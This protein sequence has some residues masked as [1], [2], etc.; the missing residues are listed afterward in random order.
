MI[1]RVLALV[2]LS[3]LRLSAATYYVRTNGNDSADGSSGTPW[4]TVAKAATTAS[5][6]DTVLIGPGRFEEYV[7]LTRSNVVFRGVGDASLEGFRVNDAPGITLEALTFRGA[8]NSLG[9]HVRV[10]NDS[11]NLTITN[12]VIGPGLFAFEFPM[13][14]NPTNS[15]VSNTNVDWAA[16]GFKVGGVIWMGSSGLTNY[17]YNSYGYSWT[18]TNISGNT[19]GL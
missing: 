15:T 16:R 8:Q 10:E 7:T 13:V 11:H 6:G 18:I 1:L 14:L 5:A 17:Q 4:L 3:A 12:C 2:V 19:L 9:S